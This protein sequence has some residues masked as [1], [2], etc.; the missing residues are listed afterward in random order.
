SLTHANRL[1]AM[2]FVLI[3]PL[4]Q[5]PVAW[6]TPRGEAEPDPQDYSAMLSLLSDYQAHS[7]QALHDKAKARPEDSFA[8]SLEMVK[9]LWAANVIAPAQ[10]SVQISTVLDR[11]QVFNRYV[12]EQSLY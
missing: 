12:I 7:V 8:V 3:Q 4:S 9:A 10:S 1:A 2:R 5:V 6:V 11:V